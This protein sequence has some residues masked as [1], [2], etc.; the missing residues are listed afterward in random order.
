MKGPQ[1]PEIPHTRKPE[2]RRIFRSAPRLLK[3]ALTFRPLLK[4]T[5]YSIRRTAIGNQER[6]RIFQSD[7]VRPTCSLKLNRIPGKRILSILWIPARKAAHIRG[8]QPDSREPK[9]GSP[10]TREPTAGACHTTKQEPRRI[11]RSAL[12]FPGDRLK[13]RALQGKIFSSTRQTAAR[14]AAQFRIYQP[15]SR[16]PRQ[17][18]AWGQQQTAEAPHMTKAARF[19][20]FQQDSGAAVQKW[21]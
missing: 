18:L 17:K 1:I 3:T 16:E 7:S 12:P 11:F 8:F 15:D 9:A 19:R 2:P 13:H 5:I 4:K 14:K 10:W 20:T 6:N 21:A